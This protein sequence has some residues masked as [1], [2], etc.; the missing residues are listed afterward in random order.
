M[1][2]GDVVKDFLEIFQTNL[3]QYRITGCDGILLPE[4]F[5]MEFYCF[6]IV[7]KK[8]HTIFE[9]IRKVFT[10]EIFM[11]QISSFKIIQLSQIFKVFGIMLDL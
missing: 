8:Y 6:R 7:L 2:M 9:G 5:I 4:N 10:D 3:K 1:L 11:Y